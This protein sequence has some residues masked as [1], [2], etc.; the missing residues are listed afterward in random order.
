M[1]RKVL[2]Q[3]LNVPMGEASSAQVKIDVGDGN[4]IVSPLPA[5]DPYLASGE[6]QY[7]DNQLPPTHSMEQEGGWACL[8]LKAQGKGQTWLRLPWAACNGATEW[9]VGLNPRMILD[10]N[11]IT[12]GGNIK[13]D[14][15]RAVIAALYAGTGGGNIELILPEAPAEVQVVAKTG[16]GNLLVQIPEG[17]AARIQATSGLGKVVVSD[18]FHPAGK[19]IYQSED[20]DR[21]AK[22]MELTLSSGA[23]SVTVSE[24]VLQPA[25]A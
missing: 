24:Q 21:A 6:L 10:L 2:T 15:S 25:R 13:I 7:L 4:L 18:R 11:A 1:A 3:Q 16:A 22:K 14:L 8:S 20:Y 19:F 23:G 17:T 12:S 9:H 5:G